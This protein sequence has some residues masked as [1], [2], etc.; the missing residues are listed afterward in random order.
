MIS[1][2]NSLRAIVGDAGV[3]E[4]GEIAG[5]VHGARYGNGQ[6]LCVV[7]P[8]S[9][10]EVS[11]VVACCSAARV[12]IIPQ[13][14]NTGVVGASTPDG[15]GTQVVLSLNRMHRRC[16]IDV[17]NRTVD[18]D[19]GVLLHELNDKLE[20]HGLWFPVDLSADP[21]IGGMVS[22]NT[23]GTRLLR[24]GDVRH[25]LLAIEAVLYDPPGQIVRFGSALRKNN[26][27]FDLK[28][29]FVG[30]SGVAG[31][32]T[33]ATLEVS[34]RPRQAT[35]ALLVPSSEEAVVS[36]LL[37]AEAQLGD[38]L[39]AFEGLSRNA[40]SVALEH[41]PTLRNPFASMP[42]PE[43]A[44]LMELASCSTRNEVDLD[45]M[46]MRF[47][48]EHLEKGEIANAIVGRGNELWELRHAVSDGSRALGKVIGFDISVRRAD[49]M[50]FR[51]EARAIV[52][53]RYPQLE[54]VDFGHM[55]ADKLPMTTRAKSPP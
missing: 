36:L 16:N 23:G 32:I 2:L 55:G 17:A 25:N 13:G 46:L 14:A 33:S 42:I 38:V 20:P 26:T 30:T 45:A 31:V 29:L 43:F 52:A 10:E 53:S 24:Y 27:G 19:A 9:V 41:V 48:E 18:V 12:Q 4:G 49:V 21:S 8:S 1:L 6:P 37:A 11:S 3:L 22:S 39:S 44:L 40:M 35:T 54:V 5:Y 15:S 47:L 7:R 28:Q 34:A 50:V 51:R